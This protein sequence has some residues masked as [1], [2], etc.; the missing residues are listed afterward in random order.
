[1]RDQ[2]ATLTRAAY[3][4]RFTPS[5]PAPARAAAPSTYPLDLPHNQ[6]GALVTWWFPVV[7]DPSDTPATQARRRRQL[8]AAAAR[9]GR[10]NR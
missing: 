2:L 3:A 4:E 7:H 6:T 10:G 8:D 5:A 1:M 9:M